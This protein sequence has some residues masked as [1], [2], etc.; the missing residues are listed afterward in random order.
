MLHF[1]DVRGQHRSLTARQLGARHDLLNLFGGE[2]YGWLRAQLPKK[3][4]VKS[5]DASGQDSGGLAHRRLQ[6]Q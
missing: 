1:L 5:T 3:V 4:P 2:G 6:D